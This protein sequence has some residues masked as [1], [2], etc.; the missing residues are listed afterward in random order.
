MWDF[1]AKKYFFQTELGIITKSLWDSERVGCCAPVDTRGPPIGKDLLYRAQAGICLMTFPKKWRVNDSLDNISHAPN[2]GQDTEARGGK[3]NDDYSH[4]EIHSPVQI[5]TV[6]QKSTH[7]FRWQVSRGLSFLSHVESVF[8]KGKKRK[9]KS[10]ESLRLRTQNV[11]RTVALE[12]SARST[13]G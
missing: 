13:C 6:M 11:Y 4:A 5:T 3:W 12:L 1:K 7:Q 10:C 2:T 8:P 9:P